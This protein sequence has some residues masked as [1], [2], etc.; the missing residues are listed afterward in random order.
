M[1][2]LSTAPE[3]LLR[4]SSP[5][6]CHPIGRPVDDIYGA[7]YRRL[8]TSNR[9]YFARYPDDR[10]RIQDILRHSRTMTFASRSRLTARRFRQL[11]LWLGDSAGFELLH[12]VVRPVRVAA[13]LHDAEAG[14]PLRPQPDL[15]DAPRVVVRRWRRDSLV[16]GAAAA[17]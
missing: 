6:G 10:E 4:R 12:H 3:G 17:R 7:T 2:Y 13:F 16:R 15:R 9:R 11:G 1:T 5:A 14:R 8:L